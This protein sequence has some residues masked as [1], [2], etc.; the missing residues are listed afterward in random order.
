MKFDA[1][2]DVEKSVQI[3]VAG[4]AVGTDHKAVFIAYMNVERVVLF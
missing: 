1:S 3:C 2:Y 4:D